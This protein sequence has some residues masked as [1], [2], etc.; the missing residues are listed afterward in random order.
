MSD[1]LPTLRKNDAHDPVLEGGPGG[2]DIAFP[3]ESQR[4]GK[5][6][7]RYFLDGKV[8]INGRDTTPDDQQPFL[9]GELEIFEPRARQGTLDHDLIVQLVDIDRDR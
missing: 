4:P 7:A 2:F 3:R 5:H 6:P 9:A 8:A 1:P